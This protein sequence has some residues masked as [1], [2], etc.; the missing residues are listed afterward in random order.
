MTLSVDLAQLPGRPA[1]T[2]RLRVSV[3]AGQRVAVTGE[4]A[5]EAWTVGS[6]VSTGEARAFADPLAPIGEP[7]TYRATHAGTVESAT[8]TRPSP[9]DCVVMLGDG[10]AGAVTEWYGEDESSLDM[11][12]TEQPIPGAPLPIHN[13]DLPL[14]GGGTLTVG[15]SGA[16]RAALAA[17]LTQRGPHILLHDATTCQIPDCDI[18]GARFVQITETAQSRIGVLPERRWGL[19]WRYTRRDTETLAPV[20][21][22]GDYQWSGFECYDIEGYTVADVAAGSPLEVAP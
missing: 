16:Q 18:P 2:V 5:R 13:P 22:V 6:Y 1:V 20:V 14:S 3:P 11:R 15:V 9:G 8:V 10:T 17:I 19:S 12:V 4:T 21:T 7:I